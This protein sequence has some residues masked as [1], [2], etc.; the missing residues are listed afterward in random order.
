MTILISADAERVATLSDILRREFPGRRVLTAPEGMMPGDMAAEE[1]R[2]LVTFRAP[3]GLHRRLPALR[4]VFSLSAGIDQFRQEDFPGQTELVRLVDPAVAASVADYVAMSVLLLHR[5]L[6]A[7]MVQKARRQWRQLPNPLPSERQVGI[8][9]LGELGRAAAERLR[10]FGFRLAGWSRTPRDV[11]GVASFT[12]AAG[13]KQMVRRSDIL[14]CLL[15]LTDETRGIIDAELLAALPEGAGLV[16][17]GR[18]PQLDQRALLAALDEGHLSAAV[19]DVTDPE[20]LPPDDPL[21]S[22]PRVILTPHVASQTRAGSAA[23]TIAE[24]IRRTERGEAMIGSVP[25]G[26]AC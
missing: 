10:P 24:N 13:L 16:H 19:L 20:P 8:L 25:R 12:G 17:A 2:Y 1:V 15:P 6:P 5:D 23:L 9:G 11:P 7:Y 21:W 18:G 26:V 14:V 22:H 3:A 4:C